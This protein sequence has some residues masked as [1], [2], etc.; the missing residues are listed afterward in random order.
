MTD[1]T[2]IDIQSKTAQ[3][4]KQLSAIELSDAVR[5]KKLAKRVK[6]MGVRA[7]LSAVS[8]ELTQLAQSAWGRNYA[9]FVGGTSD[10]LDQYV[11]ALPKE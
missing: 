2:T 8:M 7:D 5:T 3:A 9:T 10:P 6:L 11:W 4:L 1:T